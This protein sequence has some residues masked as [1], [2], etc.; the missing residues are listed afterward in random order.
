MKKIKL[1]D[2]KKIEKDGWKISPEGRKVI[3]SQKSAL[4][5]Y[6]TAETIASYIKRIAQTTET[7]HNTSAISGVKIETMLNSQ[8]LL[9]EQVA[10]HLKKI[11]DKKRFSKWRVVPT[12]NKNGMIRHIDVTAK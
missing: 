5:V 4:Q 9:L 6:D 12:R 10:G 7:M 1:A 8:Q 3:S 11:A 2:V